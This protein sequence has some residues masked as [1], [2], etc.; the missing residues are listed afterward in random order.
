MRAPDRSPGVPQGY[1][2]RAVNG[3]RVAHY[4]DVKAFRIESMCGAGVWTFWQWCGSTDREAAEVRR[5]PVCMS[6][7]R[8]SAVTR[9][10]PGK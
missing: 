2:L 7:M 1:A 6:C 5:L 3:G 10:R 4:V 8:T 9:P